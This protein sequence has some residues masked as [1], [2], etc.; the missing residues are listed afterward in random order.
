[1][2]DFAKLPLDTF[3]AFQVNSEIPVRQEAKT[4]WLLDWDAA[5]VRI[6]WP[7]GLTPKQAILRWA[8][9]QKDA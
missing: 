3:T 9:E 7:E 6:P 2:A 5:D 8:R 4:C 1:M